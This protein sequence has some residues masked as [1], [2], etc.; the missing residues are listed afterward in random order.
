MGRPRLTIV[1]PSFN[2]GEFLEETIKSV[3]DQEYE[4]LEYIVV[5]GGSTDRSVSIIKKY[6]HRLA[7]WVSE[8]DE[9]QYHAIN[10]GFARA[11]GEIM[12]WLN[13]DDKYLP[14]TL[15]VVADIFSAFPEVEWLTSVHPLQ[16]NSHGQAV[17]V[18]FTGA[19]SRHSFL[20][21]NNFPVEGSIGR[22]WIQQESTFWRRSLWER[23]GGRLDQSLA[24]AADFELWA[25]FYD[26]ADLF[27]AQALL[28]GF[29]SHGVQRS[30]LHRDRYMAE[31]EQVLRAKGRWPTGWLESVVREITWKIFRQHSLVRLP[32][33][34]QML[35]FRTGI[36]YPARVIVWSG[37][38][39]EIITGFTV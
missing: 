28:G 24:M 19:L 2:Q 27:G 20:Q 33:L 30:V 5:D 6:S 14:W 26:H 17:A 23:A 8:P 18:D 4:N 12:A 25:R 34:L 10:K 15:S 13:S 36:L 35:L 22:R 37:K 21:G 9:G 38:E 7:H 16:W 11:T 3:L 39:W 32:K 1:T 31:A 29:R